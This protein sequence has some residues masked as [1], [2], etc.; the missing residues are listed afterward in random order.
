M[1]NSYSVE[2]KFERAMDGMDQQEKFDF[3]TQKVKER[4]L[5]KRKLIRKT[6]I[7]ASMAVIF[8]LIACLTFLILQPVINNWLHPQEEIESIEIPVAEDEVLPEEMVEHEEEI[9]E[10]SPEVIESLK[11][12]IRLEVQDFQEIY[13]NVYNIVKNMEAAMV[14]VEG[15]SAQMDWFN[16]PYEATDQYTGFIFAQ[17]N[18]E[19]LILVNAHAIG[20]E[21]K[22]EVTFVDGRKVT[23]YIKG[24]DNN[25]QLAVVAVAKNSLVKSTQDVLSYVELGNSKKTDLL[26]SPVIAVGNPL[27]KPSVVYG[28]ITSVG[29][30]VSMTDTNYELLTTDMYGSTDAEGLLIDYNGKVVG[31]IYQKQNNEDSRNLISALGITELKPVL[32]RMGNGIPNTY[33]GLQVTEVL[34]EIHEIKE[35]PLGV[36]VTGLVMDSPAMIFGIQS[37]D[38]I[39]QIDESKITTLADYKQVIA[40]SNPGEIKEITIMRQGP[41]GYKEVSIDLTMGELQ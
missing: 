36:Y 26:A 35:I 38:I 25:T 41:D 34:E 33:I 17:N 6:L 15:V 28:M 7:T 2:R 14:T 3:I 30:V 22:I 9:M 1:L 29:D 40:Q 11:N 31:I 21:E 5:N 24:R 27:G 16:S 8:G 39:V 10:P 13:S 32:Q 19:I 4:P 37:G 12:E 23:A 20:S 18:A